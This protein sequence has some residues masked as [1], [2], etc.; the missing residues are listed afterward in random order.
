MT[1]PPRQRSVLVGI[2]DSGIL[3]H[4]REERQPAHRLR[5]VTGPE[6]TAVCVLPRGQLVADGAR[7]GD[8]LAQPQLQVDL[9]LEDTRIEGHEGMATRGGRSQGLCSQT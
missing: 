9:A 6:K 3:S 4:A 2:R 7:V 5:G 1:R 8:D